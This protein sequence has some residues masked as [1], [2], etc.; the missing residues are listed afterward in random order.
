MFARYKENDTPMVVGAYDESSVV[1]HGVDC[2]CCRDFKSGPAD[3]EWSLALCA[4]SAFH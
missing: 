4:L 1:R 3:S 2:M